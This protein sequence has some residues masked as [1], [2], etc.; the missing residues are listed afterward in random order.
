MDHVPSAVLPATPERAGPERRQHPRSPITRPCKL[1]R[2][3]TGRYESGQ[4]V[5]LSS[6]GAL[7]EVVAPRPLAQ[8][9]RVRLGVLWSGAGVLRDDRLLEARVVRSHRSD[10]GRQT[11]AVEFA[12]ALSAAA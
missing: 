2:C 7:V 11:V 5:N 9:D 3:A 10:N 8:G 6:S 4:I 12:P 1:F